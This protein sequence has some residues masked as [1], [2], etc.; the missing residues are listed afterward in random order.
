MSRTP[1]NIYSPLR[2]LALAVGSGQDGVLAHDR[3][4]AFVPPG[5]VAVLDPEGD[6]PWEL[7][8]FGLVDG[9]G[10]VGGALVRVRFAD[11]ADR[12]VRDAW[13]RGRVHALNLL[14]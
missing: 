10:A 7:V 12:I 13:I 1:E 2:E 5:T 4:A 9:H 11:A 6:H 3:P 8:A 14:V